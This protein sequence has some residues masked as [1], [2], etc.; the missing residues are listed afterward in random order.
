MSVAFF[1]LEKAATVDRYAERTDDVASKRSLQLTAET[2]RLLAQLA[3]EHSFDDLP[4]VRRR[5]L[6]P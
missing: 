5:L 1:Y 4:A 3:E 6:E 2:W